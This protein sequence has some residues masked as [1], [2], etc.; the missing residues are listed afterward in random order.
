MLNLTMPYLPIR[1]HASNFHESVASLMDLGILKLWSR[2]AYEILSLIS[3]LQLIVVYLHY[4]QFSLLTE[5]VTLL[6]VTF[7]L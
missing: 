7:S 1:K 2:S 6:K 4:L 3:L 5:L